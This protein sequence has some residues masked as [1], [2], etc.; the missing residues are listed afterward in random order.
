[1]RPRDDQTPTSAPATPTPL[2]AD[3][4]GKPSPDKKTASASPRRQDASTGDET[5]TDK[6]PRPPPVGVDATA[7]TQAAIDGHQRASPTTAPPRADKPTEADPPQATT[8]PRPQGPD[9]TWHGE[10]FAQQIVDTLYPTREDLVLQGRRG[11]PP[12]GPDEFHDRELGC[13]RRAWDDALAGLGQA[14]TAQLLRRSLKE[15]TRTLK[16]RCKTTRGR[17]WRWW[18]GRHIAAM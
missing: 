9:M 11:R 5:E 14:E 3:G 8:S 4:D 18:F 16:I 1:M 2:S 13:I 15:A 6:P 17:Y 10:K 12:Q 7:G